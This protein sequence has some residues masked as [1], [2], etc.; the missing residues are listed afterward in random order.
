[1]LKLNVITALGFLPWLIPL[2]V[3]FCTDLLVLYDTNIRYDDRIFKIIIKLVYV[4][5]I[6]SSLNVIKHN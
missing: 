4:A 1:M 5:L 6:I 3:R 2:S